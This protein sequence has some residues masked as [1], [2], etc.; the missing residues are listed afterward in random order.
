M[1]SFWASSPLRG[2]SIPQV[3]VRQSRFG[4]GVFALEY[5]PAGTVIGEYP[6]V[7]RS[8]HDFHSK[9][10]RTGK[11]T[12]QYG[13]TC[14]AGRVGVGGGRG[15]AMMTSLR[16]FA[17]SSTVR[18]SSDSRH[19]KLPQSHEHVAVRVFFLSSCYSMQH[20]LTFLFVGAVS[21]K[22]GNRFRARHWRTDG[23]FL[24]PT[25]DN[26]TLPSSGQGARRGGGPKGGSSRLP[27]SFSVS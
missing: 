22:L 20:H 12:Q 24:D 10:M 26:G 15:K 14:L 3:E 23:W 7:R 21:P 8:L 25:D 9:N 19:H 11:R 17:S 18:S 5:L 4:N 16:V 2:S 13:M 27:A 6:G 1:S